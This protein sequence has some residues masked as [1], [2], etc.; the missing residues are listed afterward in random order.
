MQ[1]V[2][3]SRAN[4]Y[5]R[6]D[7]SCQYCGD[8]LR[9]RRADLRSRRAG[10][11]GRP[12][13]LGEHRHLLHHVQSPEGRPDAGAGGHAPDPARRGVPTRRPRSAS[14]S[15]SA[16]RRRAGATTSTG[17]SNSTTRSRMLGTRDC[18]VVLR[19]PRCGPFRAASS[20][21]PAIDLPLGPAGP[22]RVCRWATCLRAC[23][24][25]RRTRLRLTVPPEHRGR[26]VA[27]RDRPERS[28]SATCMVARPV[29]TGLHQ[30]DSPAFDGLG[31][32]YVTQSGSRGVKVPVPLFR[33]RADG[34]TRADRRRSA[35]SHVDGARAG[36]RAVRL[37]PVRRPGLP[38]DHR[39]PRRDVRRRAGRADR[40]GVRARRRAVRRRSVGFDLPRLARSARR[41]VRL[42]AGERGGVSPR[43]RAR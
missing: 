39:R 25:R 40:A 41:D 16:T 1:H 24:P 2:P 4:I 12:Q 21:S 33:V 30:V 34:G 19:S 28:R 15:V 38:A 37:E 6:D 22:P 42:A 27:V 31:R 8:A 7:H 23:S 5:A 17:T 29:A 36:W 10:G 14:R 43:V 35:E 9:R 13:G 26:L 11:A 3:F 18:A 20:R 32:L